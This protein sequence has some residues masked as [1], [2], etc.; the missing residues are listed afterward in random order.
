M[1]DSVARDAHFAPFLGFGG[2]GGHGR[3]TPP[4]WI[5]QWVNLPSG[6]V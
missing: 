1:V 6:G 2:G 5:R 3:A 4:P